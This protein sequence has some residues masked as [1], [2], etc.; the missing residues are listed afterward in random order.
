MYMQ[1]GFESSVKVRV[2]ETFGGGQIRGQKG[3]DSSVKARV[4]ET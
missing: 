4:S 2:S 3:F 1:F